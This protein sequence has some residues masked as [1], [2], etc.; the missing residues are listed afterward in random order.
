[1]LRVPFNRF[2]NF[3]LYKHKTLK[4]LLSFESS[5][6]IATTIS[7][8]QINPCMCVNFFMPI[9]DKTFSFDSICTHLHMI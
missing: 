6:C 5:Q 7:M 9:S 1:M 3:Y 2:S 4:T 8:F